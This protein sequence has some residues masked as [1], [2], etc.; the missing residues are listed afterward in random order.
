MRFLYLKDPL[1]IFC[2]ALYFV[3]RWVLKPYLP[4][5]FSKSFLNDVICIPFWVPIMLFG[6]R[7]LKLRQDDLP[8]QGYEILI[9]LFIWSWVFEIYLPSV[10]FFKHLAT[11][12]YQDI[13]CYTVGAFLAAIFWKIW[14]RKSERG[15]FI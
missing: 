8:P 1:F 15:S 4:N 12:D 2:V 14:Y 5:E 11:S 10:P 3:N 9:P 6:M 13:L 7:K